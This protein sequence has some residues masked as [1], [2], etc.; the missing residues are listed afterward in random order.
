MPAIRQDAPRAL[1]PSP[2]NRQ[3]IPQ[4]SILYKIHCYGAFPQRC[5]AFSQR[6]GA[7]SQRCGAF[8]QRCG[9][10]LQR[11]GAFL[12]RYGAFP[13]RYGAFLQHCG[14]FFSLHLAST[15]E[16]YGRYELK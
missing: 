1:R 11:C 13:Q 7:F 12:Q 5:G 10:F 16:A 4:R 8:L 14:A 2:R 15:L 3:H 6:C 9:A